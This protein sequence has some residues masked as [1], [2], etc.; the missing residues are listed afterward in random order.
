MFSEVVSHNQLKRFCTDFI[1]TVSNSLPTSKKNRT[2]LIVGIVVGG[3]VLLVLL[4]VAFYL[5][6][7]RKRSD[8]DDDEGKLLLLFL[9][10]EI[11]H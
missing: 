3:G 11:Y 6:Q 1:P 4:F 5:I 10:N 8:P 7:R 2:G 9:F